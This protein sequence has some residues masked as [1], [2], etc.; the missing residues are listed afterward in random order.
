MLIFFSYL[1]LVGSSVFAADTVPG[2]TGGM[3]LTAALDMN[4]YKGKNL[5]VFFYS[6]DDPR[7]SEAV[8]LMN[9]LYRIRREYNFDIVGIAI[10]PD[11]AEAVQ[12]Y[13]RQN[14]VAFPVYL[15]SSLLLSSR[16]KMTGGIGFY[17]FN[18]QGKWLATKLGSH[19]PQEFNL[20]ENWRVFASSHLKFGYFPAD[21]PL[22]GIKPPLPLFKGKTLSS[23]ILDIKEQ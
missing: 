12:Q 9:E 18:K 4:I 16:F 3:H 21:E 13:N 6:I 2:I 14:S 17:L 15:D 19:T 7:C 20:A 1:L 8:Q 23:S 5:L 11:K 10:N 22:L